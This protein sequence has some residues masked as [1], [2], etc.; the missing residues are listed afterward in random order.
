M[1]LLGREACDAAVG[2]EIVAWAERASGSIGERIRGIVP[3]WG[4]SIGNVVD[5]EGVA[6][7]PDDE[8]EREEPSRV[9][10]D[11]VAFDELEE[12]GVGRCLGITHVA[13]GGLMGVG[14]ELDV[15]EGG[16][17][18]LVRHVGQTR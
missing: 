3:R 2:N 12:S 4:G 7:E 15:G 17:G 18:L 10:K 11:A 16:W 9:G 5:V 13:A 1:H 14:W 6:G 8:E